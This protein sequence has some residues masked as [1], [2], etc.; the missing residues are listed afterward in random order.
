[1]KRVVTT[2]LSIEFDKMTVKQET[3]TEVS[4]DELYAFDPDEPWW[5]R[6]QHVTYQDRGYWVNLYSQ[7]R[8][9]SEVQ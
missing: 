6:Q 1:M 7:L 9:T 2:Q 4:L 3:V 8:K 5:N